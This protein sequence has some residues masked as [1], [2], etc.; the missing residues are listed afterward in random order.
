[1]K[2]LSPV[3]ED[4]STKDKQPLKDHHQSNETEFPSQKRIVLKAIYD[5][6]ARNQFDKL[7]EYLNDKKIFGNDRKKLI[8]EFEEIY[9]K[10]YRGSFNSAR[11]FQFW[12]PDS[13]ALDKFI[14]ELRELELT[15]S[16]IKVDI[17]TKFSLRLKNPD[18]EYSER[19]ITSVIS[20]I[21]NHIKKNNIALTKEE[22]ELIEKVEATRSISDLIKLVNYFQDQNKFAFIFIAESMGDLYDSNHKKGFRNYSLSDFFYKVLL[23]G[24]STDNN[25]KS[26]LVESGVKVSIINV[27]TDL[28]NITY[29]GRGGKDSDLKIEKPINESI[30]L[31]NKM[32]IKEVEKF[33]K[34][35]YGSSVFLAISRTYPQLFLLRTL[36]LGL[37]Q[38]VKSAGEHFGK[39]NSIFFRFKQQGVFS[40]DEEHD[41]SY[42]NDDVLLEAASR[43]WLLRS[44]RIRNLEKNDFYQ[45]NTKAFNY[46][47]EML[48]GNFKLP[49]IFLECLFHSLQIYRL[50]NNS[51]ENIERI[52]L[53]KSFVLQN[54]ELSADI[55]VSSIKQDAVLMSIIDDKVMKIL[56]K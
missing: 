4:K 11:I 22:I 3:E 9:G 34:E 50:D 27:R 8:R 7:V 5:L 46:Y 51:S 10:G 36:T 17:D 2:R 40:F 56:S 13:V 55:L 26:V 37:L 29:S 18:K 30:S 43:Y 31:I 48:K 28:R 6:D 33:I 20:A 19:L 21:G 1:M 25:S 45:V 54:N 44:K 42:K 41:G 32:D 53:M 47:L 12:S 24:R 35:N 23:H 16:I 15:N 38:N 39:I 52:K 14:N 49:N